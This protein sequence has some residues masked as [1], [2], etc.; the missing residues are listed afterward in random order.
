MRG[1]EEREC[2]KKRAA[3]VRSC[4]FSRR[5]GRDGPPIAG[6]RLRQVIAERGPHHVVDGLG[7]DARSAG[8]AGLGYVGVLDAPAHATLRTLVELVPEPESAFLDEADVARASATAGWGELVRRRILGAATAVVGSR[9]AVRNAERE[10]VGESDALA[11]F[12][13]G[14]KQTLGNAESPQGVLAFGFR[15]LEIVVLRVSKD[16]IEWQEPGFDVAEFVPPAITKISFSNCVVEWA[17]VQV[18]HHAPPS[19]SSGAGMAQ[20]E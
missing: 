11:M 20:S 13:G 19:I 5:H 15:R 17:R 6:P 7:S 3:R 18:V 9:V 16:V 2:K 14:E 1:L 10:S 4:P 8:P 12:S